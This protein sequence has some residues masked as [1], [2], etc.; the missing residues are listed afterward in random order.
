M[1][2]YH[3]TTIERLPSI[4]REGLRPHV[5]GITWDGGDPGVARL[6]FG[7]AVVWLTTDPNEWR[8]DGGT[9][10][11][12][13]ADARRLTV[14]LEANNKRLIEFWPWALKHNPHAIKAS[15]H[16]EYLFATGHRSDLPN[17]R[18]WW[19]YRGTIAPERIVEGLTME[20]EAA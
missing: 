1:K 14:R 8:H 16:A 20:A 17:F 3:T 9:A 7:D 5:P 12:F 18:A 15:E 6:T 10:E 11:A 4:A 2:F 13:S 19:I